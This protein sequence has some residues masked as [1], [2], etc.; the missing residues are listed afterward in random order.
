VLVGVFVLAVSG[1][2][3]GWLASGSS[4]GATGLCASAPTGLKERSF[5]KGLYEATVE[6]TNF[7]FG[8]VDDFYGIGASAGRRWPRG[9]ITIV[10]INEGPDA[11]PPVRS[12]LRVGTT[13]FGGFEG[14]SWPVAHVAI[15][16]QD[17]FLDAYAEVR[18]VTPAAV[19]T[20]NRALADVRACRA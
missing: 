17:R 15:R 3:A 7:H 9:G 13:D 4:A 2:V 1:A 12:A 19:A 6:L 11:S 16:S 20:V 8:G 14:S 10:V 18:T 5:P